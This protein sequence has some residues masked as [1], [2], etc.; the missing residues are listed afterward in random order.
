MS[1]D[2]D[3]VLAVARNEKQPSA[4]KEIIKDPMYLEFL[5]L[6][7]EA[8][9]YEKDLEQAIIT[10]LH[11][12]LSEMGNGFE[13]MMNETTPFRRKVTYHTLAFCTVLSF[14]VIKIS[15]GFIDK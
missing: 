8:S 6:H 3:S 10:H 5:G 14:K 12:F 7:R 13:I 11:D 4:A 2:K 9:Y 15:P 1:N